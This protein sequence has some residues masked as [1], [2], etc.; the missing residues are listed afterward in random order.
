MNEGETKLRQRRKE[1][2]GNS[3]FLEKLNKYRKQKI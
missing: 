3:L 1:A 2:F